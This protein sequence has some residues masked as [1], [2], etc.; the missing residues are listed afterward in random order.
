MNQEPEKAHQYWLAAAEQR[1]KDA[2]YKLGLSYMEGYGTTQNS[3]KGIKYLLKA[4]RQGHADATFFLGSIYDEGSALV[5]DVSKNLGK[6]LKFYQ[7]GASIKH[8]PSIDR[9]QQLLKDLSV[10]VR[11]GV[12]SLLDI[13]CTAIER[14]FFVSR[15]I[16]PVKPSRRD[17]RYGMVEGKKVKDDQQLCKLMALPSE[18][19][20]R[21]SIK[22]QTT[23]AK[24]SCTNTFCGPGKVQKL[25]YEMEENSL[26]G[27]RIRKKASVLTLSFCSVGC[28]STHLS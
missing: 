2:Q 18:L 24:I 1:E 15:E 17:P 25:Y 12:S 7:D 19:C 13:C 3:K 6:A 28:A 27:S 5:K 4:S 22:R 21:L 10:D 23:C 20:D 8:A 11:F 14:A 9:Y 16:T 26:K